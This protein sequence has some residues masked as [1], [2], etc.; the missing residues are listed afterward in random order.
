MQMFEGL[1]LS[2]YGELFDPFHMPS[3]INISDTALFPITP[4][5]QRYMSGDSNIRK[6][7][8]ACW[9]R[10]NERLIHPVVHHSCSLTDSTFWLRQ[11]GMDE[12]N[13]RFQLNPK[14]GVSPKLYAE[15]KSQPGV[16]LIFMWH[17][18]LRL[19][20]QEISHRGRLN[21]RA[22]FWN[23]VTDGVHPLSRIQ[24]LHS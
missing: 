5:C 12:R 24:I 2:Y 10:G 23:I 14:N 15:T 20:V 1:I 22:Y 3:R 8:V 11:C 17:F 16:G 4:H 13:S 19:S 6:A 7:E 18:D 9:W 21:L